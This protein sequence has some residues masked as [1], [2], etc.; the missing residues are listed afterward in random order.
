MPAGDHPVSRQIRADSAP[1]LLHHHV[2]VN[3]PGKE[4]DKPGHHLDVPEI[5]VRMWFIICIWSLIIRCCFQEI[6][7]FLTP[8]RAWMINSVAT[9][10][11]QQR[12]R[13]SEIHG[14][15]HDRN[16]SSM[17]FATRCKTCLLPRYNTAH[18]HHV[19]PHKQAQNQ[20]LVQTLRQI[21][22]EPAD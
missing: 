7:N 16:A 8:S 10:L 13:Q 6:G 17:V 12:T 15:L 19:H 14:R 9:P 2:Q 3:R 4:H 21:K 20:G 1:G 18:Q 5:G 22:P 11:T